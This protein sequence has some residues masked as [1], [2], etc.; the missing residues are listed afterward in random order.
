MPPRPDD[1][2]LNHAPLPPAAHR[3]PRN[4][5]LPGH[6]AGL[7]GLALLLSSFGATA[8]PPSVPDAGQALRDAQSN[9]LSL[10]DP[11][12]LD[13]EKPKPQDKVA[14]DAVPEGPRVLVKEFRV[15]GNRVF[16][17]TRLLAL[18]ADLQGRELSLAQLHA[19]ASGSASSTSSRAMCWPVPT[20]PPRRSTTARFASRSSR[21]ATARS[22]CG[23]PRAPSTGYC[24]N[25]LRPGKR[26][27][28]EG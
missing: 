24:D 28:G 6:R 18:L 26:Q 21:D 20:C 27:R 4:Q 14:A 11:V 25:P 17:S 8:A 16:D 12:K 13:P 15:G 10:P 7:A 19:A 22:T 23:I 3:P 1:F 2:P 9:R 5:A